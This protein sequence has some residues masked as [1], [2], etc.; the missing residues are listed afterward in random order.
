M[1]DE[2]SIIESFLSNRTEET[3]FAVFKCFCPR[4]R[5]FYMLRG[6]DQFAAEELTQDVFF[7]VYRKASGLR[8][9]ECFTGWLYAIARNV[10][11]DYKRSRAGRTDAIDIE[12]LTTELI[13]TLSEKPKTAPAIELIEC[14][15]TLHPETRELVILRFV[16]GLNYDE[17]AVAMKIPVG[18]LK[19]RVS[20]VRKKLAL[21]LAPNAG[22]YQQIRNKT[23]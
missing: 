5:R 3:F 16:E 13:E 8:D 2:R 9:G 20:E 10:M 23:S 15:E 12:P 18:T 22:N 14:L 7:K 11:A 17:L 1:T 21:I 19:W 4:I 6:L